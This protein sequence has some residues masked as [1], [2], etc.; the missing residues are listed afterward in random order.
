MSKLKVVLPVIIALLIAG[1]GSFLLFQ[2]MKSLPE[3]ESVTEVEKVETIDVA[4]AATELSWGTKINPDMVKMVPF[5]KSSLPVGYTGDIETIKGRVLITP[6]KPTEPILESKLAPEDVTIGGVSAVLKHGTRAI[7]VKGNKVSGISGFIRP[8]DKVDV[9]VTINNPKTKQSTTKQVL[10]NILVL[11][12][13]K[14]MHNDETNKS[15]PVGVYTLEVTPEQAEEL[16]LVASKGRL[17]FALRNPKDTET[18]LT[19]GSKIAKTLDNL[20]PENPPPP[21]VAG[22]KIPKPFPVR[23]SHTVE[24]I[25]GGKVIKKKFKL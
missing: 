24:I 6:L 3:R 8:G 16:L 23:P 10:E 20:S 1:A 5:L 12:T 14:E 18:I 19:K 17:Q 9:Y 22:K 2:W 25:S 21:K 4:V 7:A 11:A 15:S 13:G